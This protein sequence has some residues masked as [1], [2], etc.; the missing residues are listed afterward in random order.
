MAGDPGGRT[1]VPYFGIRGSGV[2]CRRQQCGGVPGG[3]LGGGP[4]DPALFRYKWRVIGS[5]LGFQQWQSAFDFNCVSATETEVHRTTYK[6]DTNRGFFLEGD[7]LGSIQVS[8]N[9]AIGAF[10]KGSWLSFTGEGQSN[11]SLIASTVIG[12][13]RAQALVPGSITIDNSTFNESFYVVAISVD[14]LL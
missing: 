3:P 14:Y 7:L 8:D 5:P 1:T 9:L 4:G 6:L 2:P 12:E 13:A 10:L 11:L